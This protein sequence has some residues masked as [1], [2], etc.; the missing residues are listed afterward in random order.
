M[1]SGVKAERDDVA[2]VSGNDSLIR[3]G[4]DV[5]RE[6]RML[7]TLSVKKDAVCCQR[8]WRRIGKKNG[9]QRGVDKFVCSIKDLCIY[10]EVRL[11]LVYAFDTFLPGA[12]HQT[13]GTHVSQ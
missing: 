3:A 10:C 4:T 8:L 7:L 6:A 1:V 11:V 13:I 5:Q 9:G 2:Q 12:L